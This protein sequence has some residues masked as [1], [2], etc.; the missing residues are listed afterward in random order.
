MG[1]T[2]SIQQ[3]YKL[4]SPFYFKKLKA[5]RKKKQESEADKSP[6]DQPDNNTWSSNVYETS[7][8]KSKAK[9]KKGL[10]G[11]VKM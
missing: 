7:V 4:Q 6:V 2:S 11:G 3:Y 10:K 5:Q 1:T 9:N 8:V